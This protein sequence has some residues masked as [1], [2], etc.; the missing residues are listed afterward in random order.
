MSK[1]D[2]ALSI[3]DLVKYRNVEIVKALQEDE[4]QL[5]Q[6][7]QEE[8]IR[9]VANRE[10]ANGKSI[11]KQEILSSIRLR[12]EQK[13]HS[14]SADQEEGKGVVRNESLP[15]KRNTFFQQDFRG[16]ESSDGERRS[17]LR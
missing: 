4:V 8:V 2:Q 6:P 15:K 3:I 17:T 16:E 1:F 5:V 13:L 10:N 7:L 9:T 12:K 11:S 14:S